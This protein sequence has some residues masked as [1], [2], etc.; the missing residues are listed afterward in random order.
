MTVNCANKTNT[1]LLLGNG[2][3]RLSYNDYILNYKGEIWGSNFIFLDYGEILTRLTGHTEVMYMAR[4]FRNKYNL[5]YEIW[6]G[7]LGKDSSCD[8]QFTSDK[9]Y[10]KNSGITLAAQALEEGYNILL[11]G[12]DMGG[13]DVYAKNHHRIDKSKWVALW[14]Q[15][16]KE[17]DPDRVA[18]VGYDHKPFLLSNENCSKYYIRYGNDEP[19]ID[20]PEYRRIH[21]TYTDRGIYFD[22]NAFCVTIKNVSNRLWELRGKIVSPGEEV[23]LPENLADRLLTGYPKDFVFV[24]GVSEDESNEQ[25]GEPIHNEQGKV[26]ARENNGSTRKRSKN[27]N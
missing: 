2:I 12:Y 8:H 9:R 18:F 6:G 27:L 5:K 19:H 16:L 17:N 26:P 20:T 1:V 21:Q 10:W 3:S 15:L 7:H 11:C 14:K 4:S 22:Q 23:L 25:R 24:K 13:Q